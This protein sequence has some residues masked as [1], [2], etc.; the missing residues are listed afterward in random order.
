MV[1][2]NLEITA[3]VHVVRSLL[4]GINPQKLGTFLAALLLICIVT[5]GNSDFLS[6]TNVNNMLSQWACAG[7]ISIGMTVVVISGGFDLSVAAAFALCAVTAAMLGQG[8]APMVAF[9]GALATGAA[10]GAANA[11]L[12]VGIQIN[13]YIATIGSAFV[14][15]GISLALTQ[16]AAFIVQN[17]EFGLIGAGRWIAGVPYSGIILIFLMLIFGFLLSKTIFGHMV[18]AIG[19]SLEASRYSGLP[20]KTIASAAYILLGLCTGLSGFISASQLNSAQANIDPG[21]LF[22]VMTIV[23]VGGTSL[24]GGVGSVFQTALGLII[25]ATITN[26]FVLLNIS[27]FYQD[28]VKG[29]IILVALSADVYFKRLRLN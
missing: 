22:D 4:K 16:N 23:V 24:V 26:G 8:H 10:I 7:I 17:P 11:V 29:V 1:N 9:A 3:R 21:I 20:V 12:A 14:V 28:I 18:Y 2:S 15:N 25:V 6:L 19:G 27:P 5:A 13:P